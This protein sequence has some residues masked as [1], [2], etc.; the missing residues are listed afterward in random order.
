[1]K[2][3]TKFKLSVK[4]IDMIEHALRDRQRTVNMHRLENPDSTTLAKQELREIADL[5]GRIHHQKNWYN[6]GGLS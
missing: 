5:L 6:P 3:N 1:M 2:P 4:D